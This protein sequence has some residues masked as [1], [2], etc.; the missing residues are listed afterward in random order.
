M[1]SEPL[2]VYQ[3]PAFLK[4]VEEGREPSAAEYFSERLRAMDGP[5]QKPAC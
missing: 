2:C 1:A 4:A 3:P 5:P